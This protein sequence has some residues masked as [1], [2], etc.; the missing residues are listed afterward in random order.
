MFMKQSYQKPSTPQNMSTKIK[1]YVHKDYLPYMNLID[2]T[3]IKEA[4]D[5]VLI[6]LEPTPFAC[7]MLLSAGIQYG[8]HTAFE[9]IYQSKTA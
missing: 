7:N 8:I 6:E 5:S 9:S 2:Y 4:Y 3:K 1:M